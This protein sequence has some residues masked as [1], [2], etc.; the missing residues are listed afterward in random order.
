MLAA[1]VRKITTIGTI[2]CLAAIGTAAAPKPANAWWNH[3]GWAGVSASMSRRRRGTTARLLPV[4]GL[5]P[6]TSL[7]RPACPRLV[8]RALARKL[9]GSRTLVVNL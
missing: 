5:L 1:T 2:L 7:L 8:P 9:L 4:T 3:Y 6:G